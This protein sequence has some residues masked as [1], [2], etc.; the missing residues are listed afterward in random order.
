MHLL[1]APLQSMWLLHPQTIWLTQPYDSV[2]Q[3]MKTLCRLYRESLYP[4][5]SEDNTIA[6][7]WAIHQLETTVNFAPK[8]VYLSWYMGGLNFQIEHHLFPKI[9]H[10]HYPA[11]APIVR[12]TAEEFG[13]TYM[14]HPSFVKALQSHISMLKRFGN[15]PSP[16]E[17]IG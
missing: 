4:I 15:L 7:D 13:L 6:K 1:F 3:Q 10:V 14:E 8:N 5:I 9:C 17:A 11:I 2:N 16:E 12:Q